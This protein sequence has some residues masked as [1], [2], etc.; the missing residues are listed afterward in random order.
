M[1]HEL[2][3]FTLQVITLIKQIPKGRVATYG[4]IAQLAGT[5][6]GA[7]Q[8]VRLLHSSSHTRDLP[9]HRVINKQGHIAM[10]SG[11]GL[12]EQASLLQSEGVLVDT[13]GNVNLGAYLYDFSG[14]RN[15]FT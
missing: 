1:S 11:Q 2:T 8:V 12:E 9:W 3:E 6:T 5:P 10:A 7:R 15:L 4:Q 13:E 14:P